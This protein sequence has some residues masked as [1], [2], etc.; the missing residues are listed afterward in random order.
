[1]SS[2]DRKVVVVTGGSSGIV[3]AARSFTAQGANFLITGRRATMLDEVVSEHRNIKGLVADA[4][5]P[6]D[7]ARTVAA[8]I[9]TWGR[10]AA[11]V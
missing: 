3:R 8:A 2:L 9:D 6:L 7:A 10:L 5:K 1:M 11:H 4:A